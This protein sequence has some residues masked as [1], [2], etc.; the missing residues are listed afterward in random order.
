M[1]R[2]TTHRTSAANGCVTLAKWTL[3][4]ALLGSMLFAHGCHGDEDHELFAKVAAWA[5]R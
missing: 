5:T 1:K 3:A 4:I 2:T